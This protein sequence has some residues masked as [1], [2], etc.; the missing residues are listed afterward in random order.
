MQD[1]EGEVERLRGDNE[2]LVAI[3]R[4]VVEDATPPPTPPGTPPTKGIE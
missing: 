3:L 2:M 4:R 1:L